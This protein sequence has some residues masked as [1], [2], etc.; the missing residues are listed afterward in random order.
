MRRVRAKLDHVCPFALMFQAC[1]GSWWRVS[2]STLDYIPPKV[3]S[4]SPLS[5]SPFQK[6]GNGVVSLA[7]ELLWT[8]IDF[9]DT[10]RPCQ[11]CPSLGTFSSL[12]SSCTWLCEV[13][14]ILS[15]RERLP[16]LLHCPSLFLE[17]SGR[18]YFRWDAQ[19]LGAGGI[20]KRRCRV[21]PGR[22]P[23]CQ[24][25]RGEDLSRRIPKI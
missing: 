3:V 14:D 21:F 25:S 4:V 17:M 8:C 15:Q 24:S 6:N 10:A 7:V 13:S 23:A 22:V 12:A 16:L 18:V 5:F 11:C 20:G 19:Q 2:V 1:A 9:S